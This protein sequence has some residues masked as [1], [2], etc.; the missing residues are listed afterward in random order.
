ALERRV[1]K[2]R[3]ERRATGDL[4][5]RPERALGRDPVPMRGPRAARIVWLDDGDELGLVRVSLGESAV[6]EVP[7]VS[8]ADHDQLDGPHRPKASGGGSSALCDW[9]GVLRQREHVPDVLLAVAHDK[10]ELAGADRSEVANARAIQTVVVQT[11]ELRV[12]VRLRHRKRRIRPF[13]DV[14][15]IARAQSAG[16]LRDPTGGGAP[17]AVAQ[18]GDLAAHEGR[19]VFRGKEVSHRILERT[20]SARTREQGQPKDGG[21]QKL[22]RPTRTW[23][24]RVPG[25]PR[26][27]RTSQKSY[28]ST[29]LSLIGRCRLTSRNRCAKW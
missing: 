1:D 4:F 16:V 13:H 21:N 20:G 29:T 25:R 10:H 19:L 12:D 17:A 6:G 7:A 27:I 11:L 5:P 8:G 3:R 2:A 28:A 23:A 24:R 26:S 9:L 15:G 18:I 22:H 14:R